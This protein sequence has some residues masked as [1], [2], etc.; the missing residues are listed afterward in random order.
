M[1]NNLPPPTLASPHN[2]QCKWSNHPAISLTYCSTTAVT[3]CNECI[4]A[5]HAFNTHGLK[6]YLCQLCHPTHVSPF[7][8]LDTV[9]I[10][11]WIVL[12][13]NPKL[14]VCKLISNNKSLDN[15]E[16]LQQ[17]PHFNISFQLP[18]HCLDDSMDRPE[19]Q[20]EAEGV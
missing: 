12:K 6:L 16:P 19:A 20:P 10:A 5:T 9:W 8:F 11:V 4:N 18:V 7:S 17:H 14:K 15:T 13:H 2:Y 3:C 1:I